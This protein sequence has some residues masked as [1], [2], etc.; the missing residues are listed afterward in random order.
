[1]AKSVSRE[2]RV[3]TIVSEFEIRADNGQTCMDY[4]MEGLAHSI[5]Y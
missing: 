1:M 3:C 2:K 5:S 4:M